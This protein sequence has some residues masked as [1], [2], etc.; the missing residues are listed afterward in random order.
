MA[1]ATDFM[2]GGW[3]DSIPI[4]PFYLMYLCWEKKN[5]M[6]SRISSVPVVH[7]SCE[8]MSRAGVVPTNSL[9]TDLIKMMALDVP[10]RSQSVWWL[11]GHATLS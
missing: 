2:K 3:L 9:S 11:H 10:P 4:L 5:G 1:I 7:L 8:T 6:R